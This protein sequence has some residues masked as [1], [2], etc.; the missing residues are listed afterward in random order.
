MNTLLSNIEMSEVE[1]FKTNVDDPAVAN[2]LLVELRAL[3]PQA[4][5]NFALDDC[6]KILRAQSDALD[7]GCVA[8]HL[9]S[10][11]YRCEVLE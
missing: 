2:G 7:F 1:V 5:L 8:D 4:K 6:D 3:Y 9:K 10:K 11:G